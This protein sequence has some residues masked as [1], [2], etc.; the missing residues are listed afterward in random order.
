MKMSA[1]TV[2]LT[3]ILG[4]CG[5]EE[6]AMAERSTGAAEG[7]AVHAET[8]PT[9][10][11]V[12]G[13]VRPTARAELATRVMARV[14]AIN[15]ELGARVTSGQTLIRLGV[16]DIAAAR[17]RASAAARLAEAAHAEAVRNA[18]RM[19]TLVQQDAVSRVQRD[20]AHLGLAKADADLA[21]ARAAVDEVEAAA[22]YAEIRAPFA[23]VVVARSVDVGDLAAPGM[24]L[25]VVERSGP[26]EAV[27][28]APTEVS[29]HVRAGDTLQ[30]E[31][32]DGRRG[33]AAV[34]AVAGGADPMTRTVEIKAQLPADWATGL[35]LTAWLPTGQH[36]GIAVP[37]AAIVRR[38]QLTGVEVVEEGR[39]VTRWIRLGREL[40]DGRV[41]VLSGLEAGERIVR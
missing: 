31:S 14:T 34:T 3:L 7:V 4:A 21:M 6:P 33:T 9:T 35:A 37:E 11:R 36:E 23:G 26:R 38:G 2:S 27:L 30:V 1:L 19:D 25:L 17:Q 18:A 28:F 15:T 39:V 41:E 16:E 24:P 22:A 13:D 29:V 10:V 20:Q 8:L 40:P 12:T 5:A 32:A